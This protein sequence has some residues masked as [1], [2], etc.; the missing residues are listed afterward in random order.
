MPLPAFLYPLFRP[1]LFKLDAETAHEWTV[2]M[3]R[4][5]HG[6]GLLR[7]PAPNPASAIEVMG[8]RFPNGIGLAAGMDKSAAAVDAWL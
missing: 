7:P 5:A 3:M 4:A 8:L 6:F 2:K 1:L